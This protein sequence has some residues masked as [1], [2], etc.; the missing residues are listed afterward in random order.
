MSKPPQNRN[1]A[2]TFAK[3]LHVLEAFDGRQPGL[4]LAEIARATGQD[5]AAAR[6]GVLTLVELGYLRQED[7]QFSLT[8]KVLA[9]SGGF[10]QA[11]QF[12]RRVQPVLNRHAARLGADITLAVRNGDAVMLVAQSTLPDSVV[13][14]GFTA[15]SSLPLL[16]T[17]MGRML[18]AC[19]DAATAQQLLAS[20]P[21]IRHT[22]ASLMERADIAARVE[23][24]A[25]DG[26]AI[27]DGE[28]ES[29]IVGF[30]VPLEDTGPNS[31]VIG[32]SAPRAQVTSQ[33]AQDDM[34]GALQLCVAELRQNQVAAH[35]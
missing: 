32:A 17:S 27:T 9:L 21:M 4:T 16:H 18:L 31:A 28:F 12:G 33:Q 11:G 14:F 10:L 20:A 34:L 29:G 3:G 25:R 22:A 2:A 30:A 19:A 8:P 23:Q 15:G 24:A 26:Y 13:S 5:R 35:L 1:L 7:R 6:R